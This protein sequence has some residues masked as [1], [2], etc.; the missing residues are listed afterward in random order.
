MFDHARERLLRIRA[1]PP[2]LTAYRAWLAE[3]RKK[4]EPRDYLFTERRALF[5][6]RRDDV[7]V[8]MPGLQVGQARR[9][10][11]IR[12]PSAGVA[13][14]VGGVH[15]RDAERILAA[16]DGQRSLLE[17]RWEAG[18][19]EETFNR[20]LRGTFGIV[21]FAPEA[22]SR[23]EARISAVQITR[24]PSS[25]YAV[26][27]SYWSNMA[28]VREW[29]DAQSAAIDAP[30]ALAELL[31]DLHVIALMG[32]D[33]NSFYDPSSR[34]AGTLVSPGSF[35]EQLPH[36]RETSEGTVFFDGLRV[37]AGFPGGVGYHHMV[38]ESV[39]DGQ[40]MRRERTFSDGGLSWGRIMHARA[41]KD[42]SFGPWF[43]PPR[44]MTDGHWRVLYQA[45]ADARQAA[46]EGN[47]DGLVRS[48]ARFH[49]AF[50]RL[51]P[52]PC[53]NQSLAMNVV[54]ALLSRVSG[55]GIPHLL[56]DHFAMRLDAP[57]YARLFGRAVDAYMVD[58]SDAAQR[59]LD[60]AQRATQAFALIQ[61]LSRMDPAAAA[62]DV[63]AS[64][65][66]AA[67]WA[68]LGDG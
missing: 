45:F 66:L 3:Q 33:L 5:E 31:K 58:T 13:V 67:R 18:V 12:C 62:E 68:L 48:A 15:P 63:L 7:A 50:I 38:C 6:P 19:D 8:P 23:L 27:R 61:E 22:V 46:A 37:H 11:V 60:L 40:A 47:R 65:R 36:V 34:V 2:E 4:G 52:F 64:R 16:M 21:V 42:A 17:V 29:F 44:P 9:G 20:F 14:E 35:I 24:F 54:N 26:V 41:E 56:L 49:Q 59:L 10:L 43:C 30:D 1:V 39:G 55:A 51:H 57:A 25:P 53:A 28:D 32:R